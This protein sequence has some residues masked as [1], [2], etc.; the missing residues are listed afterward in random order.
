MRDEVEDNAVQEYPLPTDMH[1]RED[2]R[3]FPSTLEDDPLVVF[4]GT[5]M[6]KFDAICAEGLKRGSEAGATLKSISYAK[7][8]MS[9]LDHWIRRR[10]EGQD[11]VIIAFRFDSLDDLDVEVAYIYDRKE[12]PSRPRVIG[13]VSVPGIYIH[14]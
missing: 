14:R 8:S 7:S 10:E 11:G 9:S 13:Y 12:L 1:I 2:Y 3:V 6:S 5:A 4:H